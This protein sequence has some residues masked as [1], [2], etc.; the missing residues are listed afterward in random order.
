MWNGLKKHNPS[1]LTS[2]GT[3]NPKEKKQR[4]LNQIVNILKIP[5]DKAIFVTHGTD[6]ANYAK[7]NIL[8]DDSPENIRAWNL[9]G[10]TGILHKNNQQT[11]NKLKNILNPSL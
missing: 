8:I 1:I 11:L 4:K 3:S 2:I 9:A 10:G 6:K 7:G 5:K